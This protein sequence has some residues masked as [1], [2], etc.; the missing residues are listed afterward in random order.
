MEVLAYGENES[1]RCLRGGKECRGR[2]ATG[3]PLKGGWRKERKGV[4][5]GGGCK[6]RRAG[7]FI[8]WGENPVDGKGEGGREMKKS[9]EGMSS[10][11]TEGGRKG[12]G[13]GEDV[14]RVEGKG[15]S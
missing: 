8:E 14:R 6:L 10:W 3:R 2:G 9:G 15:G 11:K 7:Y 5:G 13:V 12:T 1:E 4:E